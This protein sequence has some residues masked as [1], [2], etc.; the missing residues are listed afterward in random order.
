MGQSYLT[1]MWKAVK[2]GVKTPIKLSLFVWWRFSWR[3]GNELLR[4][5]DPGI[6]IRSGSRNLGQIRIQV[7]ESDPDPGIWVR[8]GPRCFGRIQVF[9]SYPDSGIL[10][11]SGSRYFVRIRTLVFGSYPDPS[12]FVGSGSRYLGRIWIRVF[13]SDPDKSPDLVFFTWSDEDADSV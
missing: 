3:R 6:W 1:F 12:D 9:G 7:I 4:V 10:V 8:S 5:S 11:G 13:W 2:S